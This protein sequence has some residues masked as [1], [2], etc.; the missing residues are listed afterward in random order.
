MQKNCQTL[1]ANIKIL[2]DKIEQAGKREAVAERKKRYDAVI[3][4]LAEVKV[5]A[6]AAEKTLNGKTVSEERLSDCDKCV[7]DFNELYVK[8]DSLK[9]D[10]QAYVPERRERKRAKWGLPVAVAGGIVAAVGLILTVAVNPIFA[11]AAA[12]GTAA[13]T[14]AFAAMIFDRKKVAEDR[15]AENRLKEIYEKKLQDAERYVEEKNRLARGLKTF[16]AGFDFGTDGLSFEEQSA[17]LKDAVKQREVCTKEIEKLQKLA[18]ELKN[19]GIETTDV[20][21]ESALVLKNKMQEANA[22]YKSELESAARINSRITV[23][24]DTVD[25]EIDLENRKA[26][27]REELA[28][29][30]KELKIYSLTAKFLEQ[31]DE[32]LK[33]RYREPLQTSLNKYLKMIAG[34]EMSATIDTDMKVAVIT[35][36]AER[37]TQFFSKGY[38]NLFEICKRFALTDVLFTG[39]KPFIILDD[40]FYNLDDAKIAAALDLVKKLSE[41][42][43]IL[44]FVCHE[45]RCF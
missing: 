21:D 23:L 16:F 20:A 36:G 42:Y 43:Q 8:E 40:P 3:A 34:A 15:G 9:T 32:T 22:W 31:A 1:D 11:I 13:A 39:E 18:A 45:S 38:R 29:C 19:Q 26:E 12:L 44:Y 5:H 17:K 35:G 33:I 6:Y 14:V 4:E 10:L 25:S 7:K 2:A 28:A 37:E 30:E 24:E 27:L 41:E